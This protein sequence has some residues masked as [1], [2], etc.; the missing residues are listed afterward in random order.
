MGPQNQ[1]FP[2]TKSAPKP[3][4]PQN[5]KCPK[6]K[7][8]P[9][10]KVPQNQKGPKTKSAPKPKVSQNKK[11][12]KTKSS[13]KPK[14]PQNQ[15]CPKTKGLPKPTPHSATVTS[16]PTRASYLLPPSVK[17]G[18]LPLHSGSLCLLLVVPLNSC[19]CSG[20]TLDL[21]IYPFVL[22]L[23]DLHTCVRLLH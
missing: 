2:I 16:D 4:V 11:W 15:K 14:V 22:Y 9:K 18:P 21:D 1:K 19:S 12:P 17:I 20:V 6:T 7:S 13:P 10:P 3:K 8:A 5:Q 23:L